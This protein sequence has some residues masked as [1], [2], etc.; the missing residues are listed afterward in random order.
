MTM[1]HLHALKDDREG[2]HA[3]RINEQW[4][5]CFT[6]GEDGPY[7]EGEEIERTVSPHPRAHEGA[8]AE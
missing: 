3:I 2:Q 7:E 8:A 1:I 6:W 4:R 5:L